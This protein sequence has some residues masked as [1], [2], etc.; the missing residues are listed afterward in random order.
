[1]WRYVLR[2]R[3]PYRTCPG[4]FELASEVV[5]AGQP[6]PDS[7]KRLWIAGGDYAVCVDFLD[8]QPPRRWSKERK[9]AVRRKRLEARIEKLAP[10]FKAELIQ[11]ELDSRQDYFSG[12]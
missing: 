7:V 11:R 6:C 8:I 3:Y 5:L 9:A 1:M 2:W 4:L 10:L 12:N